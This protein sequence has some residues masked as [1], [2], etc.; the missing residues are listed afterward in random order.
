M[1]TPKTTNAAQKDWQIFTPPINT[2]DPYTYYKNT[3]DRRAFLVVD[4]DRL[5]TFNNGEA[6][7]VLIEWGKTRHFPTYLS[8]AAFTDLVAEKKLVL[9]T[10]T[11]QG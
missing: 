6:R 8:L 5:G 7:V 4:V 1:N 2:P 10:P 9:F 3:K 11:F